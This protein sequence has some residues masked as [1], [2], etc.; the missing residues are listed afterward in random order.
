V[1]EPVDV[2]DVDEP[3]WIVLRSTAEPTAT[4]QSTSYIA[5]SSILPRSALSVTQPRG[6]PPAAHTTATLPM[7]SQYLHPSPLIQT[8]VAD[9]HRPPASFADT[10]VS[11]STNVPATP[12]PASFPLVELLPPIPTRVT[13]ISQ[14][15]PTLTAET[16]VRVPTATPYPAHCHPPLAP[17][18]H[19]VPPLHI[20]ITHVHLCTLILVCLQVLMLTRTLTYRYLQLLLLP[21]HLLLSR[22]CSTTLAKA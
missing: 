5:H 19:T 16:V 20:I 14:A 17:V 11:T 3:V 8:V 1:Y 6:T 15:R 18:T 9:I 4:T 21:L 22:R 12:V 7:Q 10:P 13:D 2:I